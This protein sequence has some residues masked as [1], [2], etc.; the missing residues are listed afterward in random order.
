MW[1]KLCLRM[2]LIY[3]NGATKRTG[4]CFLGTWKTK[5]FNS[6]MIRRCDQIFV[7]FCNY[8]FFSYNWC[9]SALLFLEYWISEII[10][11][12]LEG[13]NNNQTNAVKVPDFFLY[14]I[15]PEVRYLLD[16]IFYIS[17]SVCILR[18]FSVFWV[19]QN[20]TTVPHE[21]K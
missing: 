16:F 10:I 2:C 12:P 19:L 9:W 20:Y 17:N 8:A 1:K 6:N 5:A 21:F 14:W 3:G 7:V 13:K 18:K 15:H 4:S 11:C